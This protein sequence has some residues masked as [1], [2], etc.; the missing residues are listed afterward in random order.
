MAITINQTAARATT[1]ASETKKK[2]EPKSGGGF[3][4]QLGRPVSSKELLFF[5]SQL[6]LMLEID[7]PINRALEAVSSQT[8]NPAFKEVLLEMLL[9][10]EDGRQLSDAMRKHPRIFSKVFSSMVKAGETVGLLKE[11]LDRLVEME[12]K[13]QALKAQIKAAMTYP[14]VL[15]SMATLVIIFVL[16]AVL[17]KFMTFFAGKESILPVTTRVLMVLSRTLQAYWYAYAAG[18]FGI[19]IG[20]YLFIKSRAGAAVIDWLTVS[21]PV[22]GRMSNKIYTCQ[23]LRTLG[24]LMESHVPL[25]EALQVTG[26]TFTN[27]YFSRFIEKIMTHVRDGGRFSQPFADYPYTLESVKQ[28]VATGEESGNLSRVMLRLADFYDDE[29]DR[30]L[31]GLSALIEPIA[32]IVMGAVIGLI[33]SSVILPMFKLASVV[34]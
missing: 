28:M 21:A 4:I 3:S 30:E 18:A 15:C 5:S 33:V 27:R 23:L 6:S 19:A 25:L 32:L 29:V 9:E 10:I 26:G 7:T 31:K 11:I 22:V 20:S 16:V 12:E 14:M 1:P 2:A 24:S 13:R 34:K 8:S 17:P